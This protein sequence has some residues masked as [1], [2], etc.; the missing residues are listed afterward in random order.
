MC[1][2]VCKNIFEQRVADVA[3]KPRAWMK[4]LL[5]CHIPFPIFFF[6]K[7]EKNVIE[8][9]ELFGWFCYKY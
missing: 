1:V 7:I 3:Q 6:L 4:M 5:E 2:C 9:M 8:Y